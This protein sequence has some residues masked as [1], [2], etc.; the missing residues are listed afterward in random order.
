MIV[1]PEFI[2][3]HLIFHLISRPTRRPPIWAFFLTIFILFDLNYFLAPPSRGGKRINYCFL[4]ISLFF[5]SF[6]FFFF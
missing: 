5:F 6:S 3:C 4:I 1:G 2:L